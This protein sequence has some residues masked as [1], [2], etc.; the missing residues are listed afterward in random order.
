M[1][2]IQH[3]DNIAQLLVRTGMVGTSHGRPVKC[4]WTTWPG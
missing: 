2:F 4:V 1:S 3:S